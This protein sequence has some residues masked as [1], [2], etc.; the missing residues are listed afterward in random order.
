MKDRVALEVITDVLPKGIPQCPWISR[1]ALLENGD[2]KVAHL[3][4]N[5]HMLCFFQALAPL[6]V[7]LCKTIG[8]AGLSKSGMEDALKGTQVFKR[9]GTSDNSEKKTQVKALSRRGMSIIHPAYLEVLFPDSPDIIVLVPDHLGRKVLIEG[10]VDNAILMKSIGLKPT[11]ESGI[12]VCISVKSILET[13]ISVGIENNGLLL[14][15]M[16]LKAQNT[17]IMILD[18][19]KVKAPVGLTAADIARIQVMLDLIMGSAKLHC[20]AVMA[21]VDIFVDILDCFD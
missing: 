19:K 13:D 9:G 6:I 16:N 8:N 10:I 2:K 21:L 15:K 3:T 4:P 7:V 20:S 14:G 12:P 1:V 17:G 11:S 18:L 5:C